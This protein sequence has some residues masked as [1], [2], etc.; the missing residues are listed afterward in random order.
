MYRKEFA[1]R[2]A[3]V[4]R[5]ND[6]K[7]TVKS[8]KHVFHISDDEGNSKD[9]VV[10]GSEKRKLYTVD[11]VD[12]IIEGCIAVAL[13][14]LREGDTVDIY[15]FGRLFLKYRK[16]RY[17]RNIET[18]EIIPVRASYTPYFAPGS[19]TREMAAL[20]RN[21]VDEREGL[22]EYIIPDEILE[23]EK[24]RGGDD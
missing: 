22:D 2:V 1:S 23:K 4:L 16:P 24:L 10:R 20:Y 19:K 9:F 6:I 5:Q 18:G 17:T 7:K 13:D 11:D 15:G 12:A 14:A 8:P 3:S 21:A